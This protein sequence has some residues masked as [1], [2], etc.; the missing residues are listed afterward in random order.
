MPLKAFVNFLFYFMLASDLW[1]YL[2]KKIV[3]SGSVNQSYYNNKLQIFNMQN[4]VSV[5]LKYNFD[6]HVWNK[7]SVWIKDVLVWN[8]MKDSS[9]RL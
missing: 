8:F 5:I 1:T 9:P 3:H 6:H 2:W 7:C 4:D